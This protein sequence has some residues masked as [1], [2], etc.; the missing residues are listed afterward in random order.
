MGKIDF[1]KEFKQLYTAPHQNVVLLDVP[2]LNYLMVHGTGD[3]NTSPAFK[4]GIESLYGVSYTLKFILKGIDPELDYVVPPLE[5]LWWA[6]DPNAFLQMNKESWKWTLM[7][8]QPRRVSEDLVREALD[9]LKIKKKRLPSQRV[10]LESLGEGLCAQTL[11]LG[12]YSEEGPTIERLHAFIRTK[13]YTLNGKHH[14]IYLGDPR[15]TEPEKLR[16][17][18]RQPIADEPH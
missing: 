9:Q 6:D 3:P 10:L 5:G 18:L 7:I 2:P 11:H 4:E 14:E 1:K 13:G 8:M 17:I 12:P 16:T 15:K